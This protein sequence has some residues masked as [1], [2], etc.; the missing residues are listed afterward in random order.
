MNSFG[1]GEMVGKGL[2]KEKRKKKKKRHDPLTFIKSVGRRVCGL[3][4]ERV[5]T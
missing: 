2:G 4:V 5:V 1:K 3:G